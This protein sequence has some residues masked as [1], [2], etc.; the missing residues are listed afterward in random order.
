MIRS[1]R[2]L[3]SSTGLVSVGDNGRGGFALH[4]AFAVG[5]FWS[6]AGH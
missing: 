4:E 3:M 5:E 1:S 2:F 6:N